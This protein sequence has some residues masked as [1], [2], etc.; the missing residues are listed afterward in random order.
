MMSS[1]LIVSVDEIYTIKLSKNFWLY[2]FI[3]S[4]YAERHDIDNTPTNQGIID[5]LRALCEN[6]LQPLRDKFHKAVTVNSGYRCYELNTAIGGSYTSQH[7]K[8]EAADVEIAGKSNYKIAKWIA[9]HLVFDQLILEHHIP[10]YPNSG[11]VHVSYR[12]DG[13]NR[14]QTLTKIKGEKGYRKGLLLEV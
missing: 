12:S 10:K 1:L 14:M 6:V 4:P 5:K 7:M 8:G 2:E 13:N 9:D 11:W 3:K